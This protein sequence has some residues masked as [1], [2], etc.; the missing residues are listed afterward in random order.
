[1]PKSPRGPANADII[2]AI[3]TAPGRGGIGVIRV[4]G[5]NLK[6]FAQAILGRSPLPRQAILANFAD[7]FGNTLD[8]GIALFF[9]S[10]HSFTGEDVLELQGHGGPAVMQLLLQRCLE[11]GAR[12]AEPGEFT[13]RAFLNDKM[14]LAQAESV[15]DLIDAASGEAAKSALRSLEGVFSQKIHDLV[16]LLINLRML[17]EATL[18]FPDEEI[19]FLET[20]HAKEKLRQIREQLEQ[21][22]ASAHQGNL[23]REGLRVVLIGQPNVGKSSLMNCLSGED[24]AIVTPIP[25][26]TRDVLRE[27]ILIAGIPVHIIDTAGL[28]ATQDEVERMGIERTRKAINKANVALLLMDAANGMSQEDLAII[29]QLPKDIPVVRV[30]NKIDLY[31]AAPKLAGG[32]IPE[33]H[34]SAKTGEGIPYLHDLLLQMAGWQQQGEGVFMARERLQALRSAMEHVDQAGE[35]WQSLEFLAEELRLAQESLNS[36]TGEFTSDDLLGEIFSRFCIGK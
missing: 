26:T 18:D 35:H 8:Q 16:A 24:V 4:S 23:L 25:G 10:P 17:V 14:D 12:P 33:V 34:L 9:P 5:P 28:R 7:G 22:L 29:E 36:I 20:A 30:M 21:V 3:A 2:A 1:M 13:K 11:L 32:A 19:D 6:P 15:A 27:E 31:G